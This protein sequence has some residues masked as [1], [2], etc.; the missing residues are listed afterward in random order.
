MQ[1]F[2]CFWQTL[3]SP[4]LTDLA[5]PLV[6]LR[7][8]LFGQI[9]KDKI[10]VSVVNSYSTLKQDVFAGRSSHVVSMLNGATLQPASNCWKRRV[11]LHLSIVVVS[12][13]LVDLALQNVTLQS[14]AL[15]LD[16]ERHYRRFDYLNVM[17]SMHWL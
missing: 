4:F 11:L 17:Q 16:V 3:D 5:L 10:L 1:E 8:W 12:I 15:L 14:V 9:V 6:C 2:L 7:E 13:E